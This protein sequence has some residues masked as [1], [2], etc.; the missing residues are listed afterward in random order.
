[1]HTVV[2]LVLQVLLR[3]GMRVIVSGENWL[4]VYIYASPSDWKSCEGKNR[5]IIPNTSKRVW[6]SGSGRTR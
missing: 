4:N 2:L 3:H 5:T 6:R 1:M